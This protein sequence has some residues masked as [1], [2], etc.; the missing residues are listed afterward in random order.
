METNIHINSP[1]IESPLLAE[2][3]QR[4]ADLKSKKVEVLLKMDLLQPSG[5]FK[6]RGIG[7]KCKKEILEKQKKQL[8]SSSGGNAGI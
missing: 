4:H 1:L 3:I 6:I 2:H 5:S 8:I 7:Y